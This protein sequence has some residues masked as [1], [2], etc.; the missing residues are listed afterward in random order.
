MIMPSNLLLCISVAGLQKT[1]Q[2]GEAQIEDKAIRSLLNPRKLRLARQAAAITSIRC[3]EV[4]SL[5][6]TG[7]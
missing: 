1:S 7:D 6:Q 3:E 4:A 2:A 5:K